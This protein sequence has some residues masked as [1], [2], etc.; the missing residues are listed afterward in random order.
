MYFRGTTVRFYVW[1]C[2]FILRQVLLYRPGYPERELSVFALLSAEI[3]GVH[4]SLTP[5]LFI[6]FMFGIWTASMLGLYGSQKNS[7]CF[8]ISWNSQPWAA[9]GYWERKLGSLQEQQVHWLTELSLPGLQCCWGIKKPS[10]PQTRSLTL[11]AWL[12]AAIIL[13]VFVCLL[14]V[15]PDLACLNSWPSGFV[16]WLGRITSV[17]PCTQWDPIHACLVSLK[18][19]KATCIYIIDQIVEF[20]KTWHWIFIISLVLLILRLLHLTRS[21]CWFLGD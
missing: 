9:C 20:S 10:H 16:F 2:L 15:S 12:K 13:F 5:F 17:H 14:A 8:R 18:T 3:K 6:C 21:V 4:Y 1:V 19:A 7:L 11:G